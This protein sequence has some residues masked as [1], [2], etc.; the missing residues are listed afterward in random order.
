MATR[1][2]RTRSAAA[3]MA[4]PASSAA[5]NPAAARPPAP[6]AIDHVHIFVADRTK[7][8]T[9]YRAVMGLERTPE[10]AAWAEGGGPLTL[11]DAAGHV[12]LALFERPVQPCRSTVALRVAGHDYGLWKEHLALALAAGVHE[13][14]HELSL[15]LYFADPDGNPYEITTYDLAPRR[16]LR[17]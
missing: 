1:K 10:L 8:E 13:E 14:D 7:A 11:Q 15:S 9:W 16:A 2:T 4:S 6:L 12:H 5:A 17:A 3:A